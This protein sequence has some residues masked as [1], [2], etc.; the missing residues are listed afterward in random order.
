M[1]ATV[2]MIAA[3]GASRS[4]SKVKGDIDPPPLAK[5]H[6]RH[7]IVLGLNDV[8]G[9][10]ER[11]SII[12]G[13]LGCIETHTPNAE[14]LLL[15]GGDLFQGTIESNLN[16][17]KSV[18]EIYNALGLTAAAVGNHEFDF[19]PVGGSTTAQDRDDDPRGALKARMREAHFTFLSAN[20]KDETTGQQPDWPNLRSS[21]MVERASFRIGLVGLSTRDTLRATISAN[22]QGLRI[23]SPATAV[24]RESQV[25]RQQGAEIVIGVGHL[26]GKCEEFED[27]TDLS[28]CAQDEELFTLL[29]GLPQATLDAFV[30]GHTHRRVAHVV[31]GTAAIESGA[32]ASYLGRIDIVDKG[33]SRT[34]TPL[35]PEPTCEGD[36]PCSYQ[37]CDVRAHV[38]PEVTA[39]AEGY[40]ATAQKKRDMPLGVRVLST[41]DQLRDGQ[42]PLG[43][44]LAD[45]ILAT[46]PKTDLAIMNGGGIRGPLRKGE[47]RYGDFFEVFPFD[48]RFA[49]VE[50]TGAKLEKLFL[51]ELIRAHHSV[52][53]I[54][55]M[56]VT[57]SCTNG[58]P[59][60]RVRTNN[61]AKL[62]PDKIYKVVT[63]DFLAT[64]G[65][66]AFVDAKVEI[67]DGPL[68]RDAM[69]E[70]LKKR[71][72]TLRAND[73]RLTKPRYP[74]R[75]V[76]KDCLPA[77]P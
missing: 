67:E 57:A 76:F 37:G 5:E 44:L 13:Y 63:S 38:R 36:E 7:L 9:N 34:I 18:V 52:L 58:K 59:S 45:L 62:V 48:N 53:S 56:N 17:G 22:V 21:M 10:I 68:M 14:V 16:E 23:E 4:Q 41:F 49:V 65:D 40:L 46:H 26:G 75:G 66:G 43:N 71:G 27:P 47:L 6:E 1:T 28:S 50:M 42:S 61:G 8:H 33:G 55:G 19:G 30:G 39:I 15:D 64:G 24:K 11:L 77:Q 73:P 54:S 72:K 32:R 70:A 60:I 29:Q 12:S 31:N 69:V 3:C 20:L 2:L 25:L 51:D 74:K 35:P